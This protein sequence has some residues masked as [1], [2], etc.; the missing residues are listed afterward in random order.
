VRI[1]HFDLAARIADLW[2]GKEGREGG[3][4]RIAGRAALSV[5]MRRK[6]KERSR[7]HFL[8]LTY[9]KCRWGMG[10]RRKREKKGGPPIVP[11]TVVS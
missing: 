6:G 5:S 1:P 3:G 10:R 2:R 11:P 9:L 7:T 4:G 8:L